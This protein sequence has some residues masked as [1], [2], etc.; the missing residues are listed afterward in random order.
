MLSA[1][2]V[3]SLIGG[4]A[5]F[6]VIWLT[7]QIR[8]NQWPHQMAARSTENSMRRAEREATARDEGRIVSTEDGSLN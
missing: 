6:S 5:W 2:W 4:L 3:G 8:M 7:R 1:A